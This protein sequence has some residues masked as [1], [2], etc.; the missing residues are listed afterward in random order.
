[1]AKEDPLLKYIIVAQA[2]ASLMQQIH[3]ATGN[4]GTLLDNMKAA[5]ELARATRKEMEAENTDLALH[6]AGFGFGERN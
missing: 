6:W 5:L 4:E 2:E 1:M 3:N